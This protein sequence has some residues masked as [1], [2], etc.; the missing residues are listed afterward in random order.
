VSS[1]A[2][3]QGRGWYVVI[4]G[5]PLPKDSSTQFTTVPALLKHHGV[6]DVDNSRNDEVDLFR[7]RDDGA[8]RGGAAL[9]PPLTYDR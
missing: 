4:G 9:R 5:Q 7:A 6:E 3:F 1:A 8:P 2:G